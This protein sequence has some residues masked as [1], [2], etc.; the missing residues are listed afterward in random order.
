MLNDPEFTQKE[1]EQELNPLGLCT[2]SLGKLKLVANILHVESCATDHEPFEFYDTHS[3][4][5][6]SSVAKDD[7]KTIEGLAELTGKSIDVLTKEREALQQELEMK[8]TGQ[9]KGTADPTHQSG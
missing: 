3:I 8:H 6:L 2:L 7:I 1:L 4:A 5:A 9:E